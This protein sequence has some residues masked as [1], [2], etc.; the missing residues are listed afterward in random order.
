MSCSADALFALLSAVFIVA[1]STVT[2]AL[3]LQ[4]VLSSLLCVLLMAL[5][6]GDS[7]WF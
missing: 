2:A 5:I 4:M 6:A 1:P 3:G 7:F